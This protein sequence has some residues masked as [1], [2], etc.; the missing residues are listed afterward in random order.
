MSCSCACVCWWVCAILGCEKR[1]KFQVNNTLEKI[2]HKLLNNVAGLENPT[3]ELLA[4]LL[5]DALPG[6]QVGAAYSGE[7]ALERCQVAPPC[8][9]IMDIS[10]PGMNGIEATL[11][12]KASVPA[13]PVVIHSN[14]DAGIFAQA[15]LEAGAASYVPKGKTQADL[16]PIVVHLLSVPAGPAP[17]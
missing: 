14:L 15:C 16:I 4:G 17:Y 12:I 5:A 13:V 8:L 9:V 1:C 10:L 6:Y 2:D 3:C 11:R 7:E